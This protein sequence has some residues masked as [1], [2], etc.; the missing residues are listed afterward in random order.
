MAIS[1]MLCCKVAWRKLSALRLKVLTLAE[2]QRQRQPVQDFAD[3]VQRHRQQIPAELP[4]LA[5]RLADLIRPKAELHRGRPQDNADWFQRG[6]RFAGFRGQER[7]ARDG[8]CR[9]GLEGLRAPP[10]MARISAIRTRR[11]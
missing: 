5:R 7:C 2:R 9:S 10:A 3:E 4:R 8:G 1:L 6:A 11:G